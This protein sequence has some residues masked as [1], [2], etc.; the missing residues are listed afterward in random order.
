MGADETVLTG[1]LSTPLRTKARGLIDSSADRRKR[2]I[3]PLGKG[4]EKG[5]VIL[6]DLGGLSAP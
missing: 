6:A 1:A 5:F 3:V 4:F 2:V